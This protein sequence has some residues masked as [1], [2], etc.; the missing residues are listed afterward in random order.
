MD[1]AIIG[2]IISIIT[3]TGGALWGL[4]QILSVVKQTALTTE[5]L[6]T[7]ITKLEEKQADKIEKLTNNISDVNKAVSKL[8]G[9]VSLLVNDRGD[10]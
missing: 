9:I 7:R 2:V 8:E 4:H 6:E 5:N 1:V 10:S 3:L